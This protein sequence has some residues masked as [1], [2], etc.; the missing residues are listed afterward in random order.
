VV[1][2]GEAVEKLLVR[3]LDDATEE[4]CRQR[5]HVD[6][7]RSGDLRD[8]ARRGRRQAR[9]QG[10]LRR[11]TRTRAI[12]W[13]SSARPGRSFSCGFST[14]PLTRLAVSASASI[15]REAALFAIARAAAGA[16]PGC[17]DH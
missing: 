6:R 4:V 11:S 17:K 3:L 12:T 13:W 2:V 16:R 1:V 10:S 8:R 14:R 7:A 15:A 5:E 9:L